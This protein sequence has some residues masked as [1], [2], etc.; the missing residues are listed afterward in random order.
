MGREL[1]AWLAAA[2]EHQITAVM[3]RQQPGLPP[4][5]ETLLISDLAS[6]EVCRQV[7]KAAADDGTIFH[8]AALTPGAAHSPGDYKNAN[9]VATEN[10]MR[11]AIAA[12]VPRFIYLSSTHACG[13]LTSGR[14]IDEDSP[15]T[16]ADEPYGASKF[17]G[18]DAVRHLAEGTKTAWTIV[19]APLVYGPGAK[20]SLAM[21]VSAVKRGLPLPLANVTENAR[22]MI[23]VRNLAAFLALCAADDRAANETFV[24]RDGTPVSTRQLVEEIATAAGKPA[25][26]LPSPP[27]LLRSA[28]KLVGAGAMAERLTGDHQVNDGK[29]RRLL[30]WEAPEPRA[31]DIKRMVEEIGK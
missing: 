13:A 30:D 26:F 5:C 12:H 17:A 28:A 27:A 19:R 24:V 4:G 9:A 3:R 1:V 21:L 18:E 8:L 25:R 22:D 7:A 16:A 23:G 14:P 6:A 29:A 10:L 11:A 15:F 20:G 2:G 31:F